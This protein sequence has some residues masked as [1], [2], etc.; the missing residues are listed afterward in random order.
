MVEIPAPLPLSK[1]PA[2]FRVIVVA[3]APGVIAQRALLNAQ[4]S[5]VLVG[6][7]RASTKGSGNFVFTGI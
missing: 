1:A 3:I 7:V 2:L 6:M 5:N 4:I